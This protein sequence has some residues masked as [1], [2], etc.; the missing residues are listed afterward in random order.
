MPPGLALPSRRALI[1]C[2]TKPRR[3]HTTRRPRRPASC[4]AIRN[5][6]SFP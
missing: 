5:A 3:P 6:A 2:P 1:N 4:C